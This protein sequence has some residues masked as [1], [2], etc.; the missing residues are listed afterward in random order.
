MNPKIPADYAEIGRW[1]RGFAAS[2]GKREDPRVEVSVEMEGVYEGRAYGVRAFLGGAAAPPVTEPPLEL[3]YREVAEGR[4]R[5]D[6]CEALAA[7]LRA[8][9]RR[10]REGLDGSLPPAGAMIRE[11]SGHRPGAAS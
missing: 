4:T 7:R 8:S 1:L 6:W 11:P 10:L 2:H 9:A 5:F 3:G